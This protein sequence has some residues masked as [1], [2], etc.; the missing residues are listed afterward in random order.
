MSHS[1]EHWSYQIVNY[2]VSTLLNGAFSV[3]AAGRAGGF[4]PEWA[5]D[6]KA[7]A[8]ALAAR[9]VMFWDFVWA[10]IAILLALASLA[11][12]L[13]GLSTLW[14]VYLAGFKNHDNKTV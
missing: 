1:R 4:F 11:C 2:L 8:V 13:G 14:R 12:A 5:A 3:L 6:T 9:G 10:G 7:E